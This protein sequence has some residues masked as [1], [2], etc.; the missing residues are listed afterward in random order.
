MLQGFGLAD[1]FEGGAKNVLNQQ[2]DALDKF[3][4]CSLPVKIVLPSV[5]GEH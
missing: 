1:P 2:V 5:L 3:A 4:I